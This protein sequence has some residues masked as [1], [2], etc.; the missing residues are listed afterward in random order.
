MI[1][2]RL[3]FAFIAVVALAVALA[4]AHAGMF[5]LFPALPWAPVGTQVDGDF[6]EWVAPAGDVDG[7]GYGDVLVGTGL[8]DGALANEGGAY[9]F[10]GSPNGSLPVHSWL[11]RSGQLDAGGQLKVASA[12]DVNGD[13]YADVLVGVPSWDTPGQMNAGKV[14]VFHGGPNGLP[15]APTYERFSP[16]LAANQPFGYAIA[17]A[18]DVNGDGYDDV[19]VGVPFNSV[20]GMTNRG[21]AYVFHGGPTGLAAAPA[22]SWFGGT[23]DGQFGFSVSGA[24]DVNGDSYA[25]VIVGAPF[26]LSG[27]GSAHLFL[28]SPAGVPAAA[29]TVILRHGRG[30]PGHVRLARR[31]CERRRLRRRAHRLARA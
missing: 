13:G 19:V 17:P 26:Q 4:P 28:G 25:D 22:R 16:V 23:A 8:E 24:G 11:W 14:A 9:L 29:D 2:R 30:E 21:A 18:G 1:P 20:V 10:R 12:G 31:R 3:A 7:D 6:G 27:N 5:V 15:P